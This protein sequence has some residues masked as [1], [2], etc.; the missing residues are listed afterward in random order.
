M[1]MMAR[2]IQYCNVAC[3]LSRVLD[4]SKFM[5][6]CLDSD[7]CGILLTSFW[8][9]DVL[10][11]GSSYLTLVIVLDVDNKTMSARSVRGMQ[12]ILFHN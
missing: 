3:L 1:T 9:W 10:R 2:R 12:N 7:G 6:R 11:L 4:N 5:F 8:S